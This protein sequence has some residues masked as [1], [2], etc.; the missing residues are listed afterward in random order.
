MD[1]YAGASIALGRKLPGWQD[2]PEALDLSFGMGGIFNLDRWGTLCLRM[3]A[4]MLA[5]GLWSEA[6]GGI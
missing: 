4:G 1:L 6:G 3:E 2:V 5:N